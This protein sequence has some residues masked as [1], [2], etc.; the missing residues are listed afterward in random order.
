MTALQVDW[1]D[2]VPPPCSRPTRYTDPGF[3]TWVLDATIAAGPRDHQDDAVLVDRR[4]VFPKGSLKVQDP[5]GAAIV[6]GL[7]PGFVLGLGDDGSPFLALGRLDD[8]TEVAA[9]GSVLRRDRSGMVSGPAD[10]TLSLK[11]VGTLTVHDAT[12][13]VGD[14]AGPTRRTLKIEGTMVTQDVIDLLVSAGGFDQQGARK[15]VAELLGYTADTLP[16]QIPFT[17]TATGH[18]G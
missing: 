7:L 16:D 2:G 4:L 3:H 9:A 18:D 5:G 12:L 17:L 1:G 6:D 11:K 15:M 14:G 13:T 10:L 8:A